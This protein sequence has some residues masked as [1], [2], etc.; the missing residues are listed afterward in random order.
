MS[1]KSPTVIDSSRLLAILRSEIRLA[2]GCTEVAAAALAAAKAAETLGMPAARLAVTVSPNIL[3]NGALAGVPG[4]PL[5]GLAAA[6]ALGAVIGR[7][8]EGLAVL[9]A[10]DADVLA[11]AR[12]ML[13]R[14]AVVLTCDSGCRET[15]YVSAEVS[16]AGARAKAVIA[17]AHDHVSE[18]WSG[19][20]RTFHDAAPSNGCDHA[21]IL[22]ETPLSRLLALAQEIPAAELEFLIEA[23][24]VNAAAAE[25][26]LRD[27]AS[28]LGPALQRR[29]AGGGDLVTARARAQALSGAAAEARMSG[30]LV[31]VMSITG[32]GNHGIANFL[33]VEGVA[34]ALGASREQLARALTIASIVTVCVKAYTGK[35]TA[36]CG[37]SIAPATGLAAAATYLMGGDA[38]VQEHAMQTVIGTFAGMLCDGAKESCAFK[39]A[40]AVGAAVDIAGLAMAGAWTP[41]ASGVVGQTIDET[42]ENLARINDPGMRETERVMLEMIEQRSVAAA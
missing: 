15:V 20:T 25:T 17:G 3:K 22:R 6:A 30:S 38:R 1:E 8:D 4:T 28:R 10:V 7:S 5:R 9:N 40:V 34:T 18:V 26:D 13:S 39:V 33:G 19:D 14:G 23:A 42:F 29:T 12:Q 2:T 11:R 36:F 37:C 41:D 27:A 31:P 21:E 24:Q 32:S 35:L 16:A